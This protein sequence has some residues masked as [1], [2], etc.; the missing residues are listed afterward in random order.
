MTR[1]L[2]FRSRALH[3]DAYAHLRR[4][5]REAPVARLE[6]RVAIAALLRRLPG[7]RLADP[8]APP[9]YENAWILH[10]PSELRLAW[11]EE[12]PARRRRGGRR[13][14]AVEL[15]ASRARRR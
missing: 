2:S 4:M 10:K 5:R 6:G 7:L 3:D 14:A 8:E 13:R 15:A 9:R 11:G 1:R 12:G